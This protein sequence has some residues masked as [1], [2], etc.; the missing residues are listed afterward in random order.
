[1]SPVPIYTVS[2]SYL[3]SVLM[4]AAGFSL[5][6]VLLRQRVADAFVAVS[7]RPVLFCRC[8]ASFN[9]DFTAAAI[10]AAIASRHSL[11]TSLY[12]ITEL[13]Q[14]PFVLTAPIGFEHGR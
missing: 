1:Y 10:W 12:S 5:I 7:H 8:F 4:D 2:G 14:L 11:Q 9:R 3:A 6:A 13:C